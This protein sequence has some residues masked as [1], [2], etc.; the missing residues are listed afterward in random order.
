MTQEYNKTLL[1]AQSAFEE[2]SDLHF[3]GSLPVKE[4]FIGKCGYQFG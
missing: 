3:R 1:E 2:Y 4:L